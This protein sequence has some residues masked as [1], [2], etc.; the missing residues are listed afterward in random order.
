[1]TQY[2]KVVEDQ[3][4]K[5]EYEKWANS[6]KQIYA[7]DGM[8]ETW[9]NSGDIHYEENKPNGRKWIVRSKMTPVQV[10]DEFSRL[11]ADTNRSVVEWDL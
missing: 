9:Y 5:L 7:H 6:V 3:K 1:M 8:I 2:D 11:E 4:R 10:K